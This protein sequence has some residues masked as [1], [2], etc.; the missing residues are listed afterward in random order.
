MTMKTL[1][2]ILLFSVTICS[3]QKELDNKS[4]HGTL[5]M[6]PDENSPV[7][8]NT[9]IIAAKKEPLPPIAPKDENPNH[10]QKPFSMVDDNDLMDSGEELQ[11][12]WNI[13]DKKIMNAY[14][15]DQFLGT[16]GITGTFFSVECRDHENVDGDRIHIYVNGVLVENNMT[17]VGRYKG[18]H[19]DLVIGKNLIE[20]IAVN[21]GLYSPNTAQFRVLND[22]GQV[23]TSQQWSLLAGVKASLIV[24][25]ER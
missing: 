8:D 21:E 22:K 2:Y 16:F 20:F 11:K 19:A 15:K 13:R 3:A 17:L 12:K 14:Q 5:E 23:I 18:V 7:D 6:Q 25:K 24:F 1:F 9:Q 10:I 4:V